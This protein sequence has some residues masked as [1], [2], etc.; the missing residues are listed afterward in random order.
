[1]HV[2]TPYAF[3]MENVLVLLLILILLLLYIL[4]I[5]QLWQSAKPLATSFIRIPPTLVTY[6][7]P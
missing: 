7:D 6:K 3:Q 5:A 1:M 2:F 4:P